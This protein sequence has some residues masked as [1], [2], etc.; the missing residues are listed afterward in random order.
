ML[1]GALQGEY[2]DGDFWNEGSRGQAVDAMAERS[3]EPNMSGYA[4]ANGTT[5]NMFEFLAQHPD[6]AKRFAGAM[7][8][9]SPAS[10]DALASYF[11]WASLPDG[12]TVVDVGGALGHVSLHL[13]RKFPHLSFVVEDMH[14]V[15]EGAEATVPEDLNGRV[16][17]L[18]HNMFTEQPV[19]DA[20]VYL[21]RYV[22]HDW[23]DK[24]CVNILQRLIPAL[25]KGAK[26]VI[27]DHLLPEPGT[28]PLLQE[29]Q[30][31]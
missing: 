2:F 22:L 13:A 17:F 21:L 3:E 23:P 29:M 9:T 27:Q 15:V 10:L 4:L 24:Y 25:K 30:L 16:R 8:S 19:K 5:L 11:D 28:L 31:R 20:E 14:E 7:S 26:I 18:G 1:A 12:S 6:R